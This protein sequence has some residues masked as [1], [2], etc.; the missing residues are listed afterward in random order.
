MRSI[1]IPALMLAVSGLQ[2]Q[3][4]DNPSYHFGFGFHFSQP[5]SDLKK[6]ADNQP[7]FGF[8]FSMPMNYGQGHVLRPRWD[9]TVHNVKTGYDPY[10]T[11]NGS[12]VFRDRR[13]TTL[14]SMT[15][16]M[17]Y[18]YYLARNIRQGPYLIVGA[19]VD[20]WNRSRDRYDPYWDHYYEDDSE[21]SSSFVGTVGFGIQF[22]RRMA[23]EVRV[24][25]SQYRLNDPLD[26]SLSYPGTRTRHATTVQT[27][28]QFRW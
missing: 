9:L 2:A 23:L 14:S 1:L 16:A 5:M 17:D 12:V 20:F 13:T 4:W 28:L 24:N 11:T 22:S 8:S 10:L 19:G 27:G 18:Q 3:S 6:D 15:L 7:G 26:S 21:S 25:Q